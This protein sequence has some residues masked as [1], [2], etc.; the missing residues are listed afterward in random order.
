M[1]EAFSKNPAVALRN[2]R[3]QARQLATKPS[4]ARAAGRLIEPVVRQCQKYR[5][6]AMMAVLKPRNGNRPLVLWPA[7]SLIS[8]F[9]KIYSTLRTATRR[10][11]VDAASSIS[12]AGRLFQNADY[13][14]NYV[15]LVFIQ[16][17]PE[18]QSNQSVAEIGR[19]GH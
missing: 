17:N 3:P 9:S 7:G 19:V 5:A 6:A 4:K 10:G 2:R 13:F 11:R 1:P 12:A 15:C 18:R 14:L 16:T 8:E